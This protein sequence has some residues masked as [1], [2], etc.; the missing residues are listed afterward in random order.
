MRLLRTLVKRDSQYQQEKVQDWASHLQ[1]IL[2]ESDAD[3]ASQNSALIQF[4]QERLRPL[5]KAKIEQRE[6]E[7]HS[8]E[9]SNRCP[10]FQPPGILNEPSEKVQDQS[11]HTARGPR[12]ARP[13]SKKH[14]KE[15]EKQHRLNH[16]R[17][18]KDSGSN[19]AIGINVTNSS[20]ARKVLSLITCFYY[21]EKGC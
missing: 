19:P 9:E 3:G 14:R 11:P 8:W 21:D 17:A 20:K 15:K 1:A 13:P 2:I 18:H 4:F 12:T 16:E 7:L 6:R 5:V 10:R